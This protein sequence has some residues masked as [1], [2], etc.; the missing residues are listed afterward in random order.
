MRLPGGGFGRVT[1]GVLIIAVILKPDQPLPALPEAV[2]TNGMVRV[3]AQ[4]EETSLSPGELGSLMGEGSARPCD[5]AVSIPD[6]HWLCADSDGFRTFP[7]AE[8]R[9]FRLQESGRLMA[10]A[11][12]ERDP[13]S[14]MDILA[15]AAELRGFDAGAFYK[16][17][18]ERKKSGD[19]SLFDTYL[20]N[21]IVPK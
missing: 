15:A 5:P 21:R 10:L 6:G 14:R 13:E 16:A 9:Q 17:L 2:V 18:Q 8:E 12:A 1:F 11:A 19:K 4:G 7:Q 3:S 20:R